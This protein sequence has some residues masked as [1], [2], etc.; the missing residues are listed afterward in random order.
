[1]SFNS[2]SFNWTLLWSWNEWSILKQNQKHSRPFGGLAFSTLKFR[3]LNYVSRLGWTDNFLFCFCYQAGT[4]WCI[5]FSFPGDGGIS[6][7]FLGTLISIRNK[8]LIS[9]RR[10]HC[11]PGWGTMIIFCI[12]A[13]RHYLT[14]LSSCHWFVMTMVVEIRRKMMR[15]EIK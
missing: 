5:L 8:F 13:T 15:N 1:M 11:Q 10:L 2:K 9:F 7:T 12:N 14:F 4:K 3:V 6:S